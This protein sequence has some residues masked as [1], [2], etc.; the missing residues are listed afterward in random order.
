MSPAHGLVSH[1]CSL[2]DIAVCHSPI[3]LG[4]VDGAHLGITP[5]LGLR[6]TKHSKMVLPALSV[7]NLSDLHPR[8]SMVTL[9]HP[10]SPRVYST[11]FYFLYYQCSFFLSFSLAHM[12]ILPIRG[13]EAILGAF[14]F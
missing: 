13:K 8:T 1:A 10:S 3:A 6:V 14:V 12:I 9:L 5:G 4:F 11:I 2:Y 7:I